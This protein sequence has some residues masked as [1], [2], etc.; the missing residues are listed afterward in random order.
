M[1][2]VGD[3]AAVEDSVVGVGDGFEEGVF[4]DADAGPA[5]V[6]LAHVHRRQCGIPCRLADMQD[7]GCRHRVFVK[8]E[9]GDI[10][11]AV[12]H[13]L[14]EFVVLVPGV[15]QEE[16][17]LARVLRIVIGELAENAQPAGDVAVAD[18]PLT[19]TGAEPIGGAGQDH[20]RGVDVGAV[21]AL[22]QSEPED[23]TLGQ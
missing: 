10:H 6:D 9:R 19:A 4:A 13:V 8:V 3:P 15:D 14:D 17:V 18:V 22:G 20:V 11:L 1:R 12:D 5:E 2:E 21:F 23:V 16:H 7:I